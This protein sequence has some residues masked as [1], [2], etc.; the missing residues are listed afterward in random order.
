MWKHY[1]TVVS[2]N[3]LQSTMWSTVKSTVRGESL[4]YSR[5]PSMRVTFTNQDVDILKLLRFDQLRY[6][7][8]L[9][10]AFT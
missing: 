3:T 10:V 6:V 7:T 9:Y 8:L 4:G 5:C 1:K 2:K